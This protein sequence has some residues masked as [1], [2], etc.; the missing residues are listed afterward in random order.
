MK[1][2]NIMCILT[3]CENSSEILPYYQLPKNYTLGDPSQYSKEYYA[4]IRDD[5]PV[6]YIMELSYDGEKL[7]K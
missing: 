3:A 5:Y 1:E 4:E 2:I 6:L 7:C